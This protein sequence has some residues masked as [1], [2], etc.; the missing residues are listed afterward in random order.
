MT[1]TYLQEA[2]KILR[3]SYIRRMPEFQLQYDELL[4]ILRPLYGLSDS[5]FYWKSTFL[6]HIQKGLKM[7]T[8][9]R[10]L[11]FYFKR[12]QD[13]L[14]GL[15][16]T[17]V[18]EKLGATNEAFE[19]ETLKTALRFGAKARQINNFTFA[20]VVISTNPGGTRAINQGPYAEKLEMLDSDCAFD[21]FRSRR[22]E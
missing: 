15:M 22:H 1:Q 10:D 6:H 18:D 13:G 11:S 21:V 3:K 20:V 17:H 7:T 14:K 12:V 9:A 19:K 8:T 4:E 5:E 16:A 2:E